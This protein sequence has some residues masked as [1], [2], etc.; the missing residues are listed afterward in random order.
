MDRVLDWFRDN[1]YAIS[2]FIAGWC[3][4][5][6]LDQFVRGNYGWAVFNAVLAYA[7]IKLARL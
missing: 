4:Y 5:G 1:S 3:A 6:A 7:N 2:L